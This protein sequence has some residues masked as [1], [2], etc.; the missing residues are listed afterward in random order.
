MT[1][2]KNGTPTEI[3]Y[4][5]GSDS[6]WEANVYYAPEK[7]NMQIVGE[8]DVVRESYEFHLVVVWQDKRDGQLYAG[9][10]SGCSCPTPFEGVG[11]PRRELKQIHRIAELDKLVIDFFEY[12]QPRQDSDYR[13]LRHKVI[14]A[15]AS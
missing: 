9:C 7:H 2:F 6:E 14:E 3:G 1:P 8:A 4:A 15:L 13:N 11:D 10:D 5:R 12:Q